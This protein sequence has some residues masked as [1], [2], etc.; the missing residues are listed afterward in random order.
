MTTKTIMNRRRAT[1]ALPLALLV[2]PFTQAAGDHGDG[3]FSE[4]P[5]P[6]PTNAPGKIEVLEFLWYGCPHCAKLE[7]YVEAWLK[8]LPTD[9]VF[10]RE[11]IVWDGRP[12][13]LVHARLFATL[14]ALDLLGTHQQAVF[15]A[16]HKSR[17]DF[18]KDT[19]M[20]EWVATRG[21]DRSLFDSTFKSFGVQTMVARMK[22]MTNTYK[23]EGVPTFFINGKYTTEPHRAG[24]EEQVL[25]IIDKLVAQERARTNR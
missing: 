12:D 3:P 20:A 17:I 21:I 15:D 11:H 4:L 7:P 1:T 2:P 16:V 8:R 6:F 9:V 13:S 25:A 10:R 14:K 18:R 24:G 5:R 22:A 19:A 23:V